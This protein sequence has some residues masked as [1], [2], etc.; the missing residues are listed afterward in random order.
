MKANYC[1][2]PLITSP[3][4]G[5]LLATE[6]DILTLNVDRANGRKP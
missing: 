6:T 3:E 1:I 5:A 4:I 2:A